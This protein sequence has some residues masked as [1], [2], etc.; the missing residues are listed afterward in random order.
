M[1]SNNTNFQLSFD[2]YDYF[3]NVSEFCK[4]QLQHNNKLKKI[5]H[6]FQSVACS[7]L[8][9]KLILNKL[10]FKKLYK[11]YNGDYYF[12]VFLFLHF[13]VNVDDLQNDKFFIK[14]F[15]VLKRL[16]YNDKKSFFYKLKLYTPKYNCC[17]LYNTVEKNLDF[18]HFNKN[19]KLKKMCDCEYYFC[20]NNDETS[21]S[22]KKNFANFVV[23]KNLEFNFCDENQLQQQQQQQSNS[24]NVNVIV[25]ETAAAATADNS[26]FYLKPE[27]YLLFLNY[28]DLNLY[29]KMFELILFYFISNKISKKN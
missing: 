9:K 29:C 1:T 8:K 15:K 10:D 22:S 2:I 7:E 25:V 4:K 17:I 19:L 5:E 11:F 14:T 26:I 24:T 27:I 28:F 20:L 13:L 23:D 18:Y 12:H 3:I 16:Y 21:S 6:F